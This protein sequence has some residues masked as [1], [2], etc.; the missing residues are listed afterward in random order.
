[1]KAATALGWM[2]FA[3]AAYAWLARPRLARWGATA[4]E[5]QLAYPGDELLPY[6]T[7]S[8]VRAITVA[9]PPA[10]IMPW[11]RQLG[12]DK[13]GFYS[14]DWLERLIGLPVHSADVVLPQF[15]QP[16]PGD[17]LQLG[18]MGGPRLARQPDAEHLVFFGRLVPGT[19]NLWSFHLRPLSRMRTR[20][21]AVSR[22]RYPPT[23]PN[24]LLWRG[25]VEP[26][27]ALMEARML[28]GIR[29]RAEH[30]AQQQRALAA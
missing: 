14:Y 4:E 27:H 20:L 15:Q 8:T 10:A 19:E 21:V 24:F 29:A 5:V 26:L 30:L 23:L 13:G 6:P 17:V 9:A 3:L 22:F 7:Y 18:P 16:Q 2:T 11:L 25:A 12:V 1:M 28:R